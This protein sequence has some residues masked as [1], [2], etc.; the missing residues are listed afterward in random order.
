M[1]YFELYEQLRTIKNT[2]PIGSIWKEKA[3]SH[4]TRLYKVDNIHKIRNGSYV[5]DV[6]FANG[7]RL[8]TK[9][10]FLSQFNEVYERVR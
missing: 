3:Y 8:W 7:G 1:S 9:G 4:L 2:A 5:V 10:V 6:V